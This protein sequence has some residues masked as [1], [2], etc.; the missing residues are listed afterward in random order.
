[1]KY[2]IIHLIWELFFLLNEVMFEC[3]IMVNKEDE[4]LFEEFLEFK[5]KRDKLRNMDDSSLNTERERHENIGEDY[6][7]SDDS[8]NSDFEDKLFHEYERF[9]N[10]YPE[11][12][13]ETDDLKL[14]IT[15]KKD[16]SKISDNKIRKEE[17]FKDLHS[18]IDE[19]SE[20]PESDDLIGYY[21]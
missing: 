11:I 8:L 20:T 16:Y 3:G 18:F 12:E 21:D 5:E 2:V 14:N 9:N 7:Y 10:N 17:F 1:M 4:K 19:F 15:L 13:L 6:T